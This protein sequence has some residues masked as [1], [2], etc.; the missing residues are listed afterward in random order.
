MILTLTL[1]PA[2]DVSIT[3]ERIVYDDRV[4]I[5]GETSQPAGK[6]INAARVLHRYGAEVEAIAP[7]GGEKGSRFAALLADSQ[8]PVTLVPVSGET[9]RNIAVT[10]ADG[11]T[12]KLDQRG[13]AMTGEELDRIKAKVLEKLPR[14]EWLTLTGSLPPSVPVPAYADLIQ[15]A[16]QHGVSTLLDTT[17]EALPVGLAAGPTLAKP[18]RPEAER[19]LGKSLLS[20]ADA[21]AGA[22]EIQSMGAEA[23]LLSL[24]SQGAVGVSGD[25]RLRALPPKTESGSPI[26]AG[27]VLGAA[28]IWA[29]SKGE[30]FIEALRWAVAAGS[31]AAGLP[32]LE[33]GDLDEVERMRSRIDVRE[34]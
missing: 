26:G 25:V 7:F 31:V 3:T 18:N 29:L 15:L 16:Q 2:V 9:R 27:D 14:A 5:T 23:V 28:C 24:G 8:I 19:L 22:V 10:D 6:G 4:Y 20:E 34:V 1:N 32:G 12:L 13:S 17:G 21:V 33:F 11:L 30:S